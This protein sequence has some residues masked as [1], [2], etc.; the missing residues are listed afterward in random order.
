MP[1]AETPPY[2]RTRTGVEHLLSASENMGNMMSY[3]EPLYAHYLMVQPL[4][5]QYRQQTAE[6]SSLWSALLMDSAIG[7]PASSFCALSCAS[8]QRLHYSISRSLFEL[9]LSLRDQDVA[10]ATAVLATH[11]EFDSVSVESMGTICKLLENESVRQEAQNSSL[12][13]VLF[14]LVRARRAA[15]SE[16][17]IAKALYTIMLLLRPKGGSEGILL[18][19]AKMSIPKIP[20]VIGVGID[21]VLGC[22]RQNL[23][24]A[25]IQEMGCWALVNMALRSSH[26][27]ALL[28]GGVIQVIVS[29]MD[30]HPTNKRVQY[31]ALF[32]LIN[33]VNMGVRHKTTTAHVPA[34]RIIDRVLESTTTFIKCRDVADRG[35]MVLYNLSLDARNHEYLRRSKVPVL[36]G[37]A[38][39]LHSNNRVLESIWNS[40]TSRL[41]RTDVLAA[42]HTGGPA[43]NFPVGHTDAVANNGMTAVNNAAHNTLAA[44]TGLAH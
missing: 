41:G 4:C 22:L 27:Q 9:T 31:R 28:H 36:M 1:L 42:G 26:K 15:G 40:T 44:P 7:A 6:R 14:E 38:V 21:S 3:F 24:H 33:L 20:S 5:K 32:A 18:R 10:K 37:Q 11:R 16:E 39:A 34:E 43:N 19:T 30:A 35:C 8:R 12:P 25:K 29:A 17:M 13:E 23:C 2:Y